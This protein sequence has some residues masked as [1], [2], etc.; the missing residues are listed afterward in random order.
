MPHEAYDE[1]L[2]VGGTSLDANPA[3]LAFEVADAERGRTADELWEEAIGELRAMVVRD[4]DAARDTIIRDYDRYSRYDFLRNRGWSKGAIE[5]F[6][7]MHFLEADLHNAFVEV[8]R[9]ELGGAYVDMVEIAG[10]MDRFPDA[11]CQRL[12]RQIRFGAQV[13]AIDQDP[14]PGPRADLGAGGRHLRRGNGHRPPGPASAL[15]GER[16]G[17][18]TGDPAR[19]RHLGSGH[20]AMGAMDPETRQPEALD[21][22][23]AS[24]ARSTTPGSRERSSRASARP[25]RSR[26]APERT[27]VVAA[28]HVCVPAPGRQTAQGMAGSRVVFLT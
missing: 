28:G 20:P 23:E 2:E 26:C 6:G 3:A 18:A 15:S 17:D 27:P 25:S 21:D 14:V 16:P 19:V 22:V 4:G 12:R 1:V 24:I 8:L 13:H 11:F 10:G 7:V 9:E 5:Y